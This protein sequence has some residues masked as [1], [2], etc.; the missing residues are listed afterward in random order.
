MRSACSMRSSKNQTMADRRSV[1]GEFLPTWSLYTESNVPS[2]VALNPGMLHQKWHPANQH[3]IKNRFT[4]MVQG[5]GTAQ[6]VTQWCVLL[7]SIP[8]SWWSN[9]STS[10]SIYIVDSG[11]RNREYSAHCSRTRKMRISDHGYI[12]CSLSTCGR[13]CQKIWQEGGEGERRKQRRTLSMSQTRER[14]GN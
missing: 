7:I 8:Q 9:S 14:A 13:R 5:A 11:V 12:T 10:P 2:I 6:S 1:L 4:N 3:I